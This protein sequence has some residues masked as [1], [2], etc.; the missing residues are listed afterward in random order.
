[1]NSGPPEQAPLLLWRLRKLFPE[2]RL[3]VEVPLAHPPHPMPS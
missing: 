3:A 2:R 1:M